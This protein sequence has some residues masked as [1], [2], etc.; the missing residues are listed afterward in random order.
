MNTWTLLVN[1]TLKSTVVLALAWLVALAL[2]RRS[3]AA[4]NLV[5]T[6]AFAILLALPLLTF[7]LPAWPHPFANGILPADSGVTFRT[8]VSVAGGPQLTAPVAQ[9]AVPAKAAPAPMDVRRMAGLAW[10][11]GALLFL[12]HMLG[13]YANVWRLRRGSSISPHDPAEFGIEEPVLLLEMADGMPMTSGVFRPT[14]FLPSES[15]EWSWERLRLVVSHEYAHIR[16]GDAATQLLARTAL[17]L[18]WFNPLAWV[19]WRELLKERERAADD[20]VLNSGALASEYAGHLLEIARTLQPA[21]TGAAAGIAMARRSQ[22][23]GRLL[24]ILDQRVKRANPG[25]AALAVALLGA[26]VV[27]APLATVRAQSQAEQKLPPDVEAAIGTANAQ[28][29]HEL[30]EQAAGSYEKLRKYDEAQK[31][32]EAALAIRKDAGTAKYA[33]GLIRLGDLARQRNQPD[34]AVKYYQRAVSLGDMPETAPALISLGLEAAFRGKDVPAAIDYL[35]RARNAAVAPNEIGRAMT[36]TAFLQQG[37]ALKASEVE[38]LYR[39]ALSIE[40]AGSGQQALTSELLARFL[41]N[42]ERASEAEPLEASAKATRKALA[43]GYST[44]HPNTAVSS[45]MKVG[46]TVSA[47][48]L[49]MKVEPEYSEEARALK[50]AATVLLKVVI[51]V[52]GY[53][54]D[55]QVAESAGLGLDEKAVQAVTA[56]RFKPGESGGVPVPVMASI[57]VNFRLL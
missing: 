9:P 48:K 34:E 4:R 37:D 7:S 40:D 47:P 28:K 32:R 38:S 39:T 24:A 41:R 23:E 21:P 49:L 51:D 35:Q 55:I 44:E 5:W 3:A 26:L 57:E 36:W 20:L 15:A 17:C 14:I 56:W 2:G 46:P 50:Y 19:A 22:L 11:G 8:G 27:A 30:L 13:A 25:R 1:L 53:A 12:L 43:A 42:H 45:V 54:K 6:A 31:L 29:N 16:R 10:A 52:D 18:H 33:V